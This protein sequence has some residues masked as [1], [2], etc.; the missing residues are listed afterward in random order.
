MLNKQPG[1][2]LDKNKDNYNKLLVILVD[3]QEEIPDDPN[4]TGNGKFQ[5]EPDPNYLYSIGS[6]PHNRKYFQDNLKPC[7]T[8]ILQQQLDLSIWNMMSIL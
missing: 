6:P 5:L 4:T 7:D 2:L 8:I 1:K 3:F